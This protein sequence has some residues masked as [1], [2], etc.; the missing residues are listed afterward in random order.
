MTAQKNSDKILIVV[1]NSEYFIHIVLYNFCTN[2][3]KKIF[4]DEYQFIKIIMGKSKFGKSVLFST[5][6]DA[7]F[8]DYLELRSFNKYRL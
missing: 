8:T 7:K 2:L 4:C 3:I 5:G 1:E 6:F